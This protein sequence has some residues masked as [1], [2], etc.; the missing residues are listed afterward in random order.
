MW[1]TYVL[2]KRIIPVYYLPNETI[3]DLPKLKELSDDNS[4]VSKIRDLALKE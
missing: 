4:S 3:L 1:K 2:K